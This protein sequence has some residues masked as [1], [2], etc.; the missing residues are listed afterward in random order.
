MGNQITRLNKY[1][2]LLLITAISFLIIL[3]AV[4]LTQGVVWASP[5][6]EKTEQASPLHP[7]FPFLDEAG[8]NVLE[9]GNPISTMNTCGACHDTAFIA[10]HSYHVSV[11]LNDISQPGETVT[12]R[13]W[14]T[15]PGVF[16][17]WNSIE[18]RYLSP[19]G[20]DRIDLTTPAWIQI[21]GLRH[22]GGGPAHICQKRRTSG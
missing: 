9:T 3:G 7:S 22:I 17:S 14:D 18:Y 13:P 11:G 10:D 2:K 21:Y 15:S 16:G 20:D 5:G 19:Q 6:Q 1:N 8:D 12:E 4:L